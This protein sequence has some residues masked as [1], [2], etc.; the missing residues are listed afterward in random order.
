MAPKKAGNV[1][2]K[3]TRILFRNF[4]GSPGKYNARGDRNFSVCLPDELAKELEKDG[5]N[6]RW[7]RPRNEEEEP[8]AILPVKVRFGG[9]G[10]PVRV[11]LITSRGKTILGEDVVSL[12][13]W[14]VITNVDLNI[15]PYHYDVNGK[16]GISAYLQDIYVTIQEDELE[17]RYADVPL[18][19]AMSYVMTPSP[20]EEQEPPF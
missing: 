14:A 15:R 12:V 7:L 3:D 20:Q 10:R 13:D 19:S 2:I 1:I 9:T 11:M 17:L 6:V 8:Q 4:S 16:Q 5:W 18:D